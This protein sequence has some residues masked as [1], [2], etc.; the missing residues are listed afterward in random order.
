MKKNMRFW[1][2]VV[3]RQWPALRQAGTYWIDKVMMHDRQRI[4]IAKLATVQSKGA[5]GA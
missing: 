1:R 4:G 3:S 2:V 5:L